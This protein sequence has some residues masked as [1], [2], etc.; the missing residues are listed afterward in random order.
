MLYEQER[1]IENDVT[2]DIEDLALQK[3]ARRQSNVFDNSMKSQNKSDSAKN[4]D[5]FAYQ[6]ED[7]KEL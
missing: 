2:Q 6:S 4:S 3:S 7:C 1:D 5:D